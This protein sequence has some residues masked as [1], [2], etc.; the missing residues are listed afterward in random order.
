MTNEEIRRL[1]RELE[2]LAAIHGARRLAELEEKFAELLRK[3]EC[4]R[5]RRIL[6]EYES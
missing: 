6:K 2:N 3:F 1:A 4:D 5:A